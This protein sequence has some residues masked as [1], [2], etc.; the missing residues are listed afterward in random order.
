MKTIAGLT[1]VYLPSTFVATIFS[2]GFFGFGDGGT[3]PLMVKR[4]IWK[5]AVI[6][7]GL[8]AVTIVCWVY[9]NAHGL[10]G[11]VR[12]KTSSKTGEGTTADELPLRAPNN[13]GKR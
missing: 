7:I 8:T 2:M 13:A 4:D 3:G 10:P 6:A 11:W 9:L 5:F 1:M 12:P